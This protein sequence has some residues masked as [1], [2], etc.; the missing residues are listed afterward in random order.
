MTEQAFGP[1]ATL[2]LYAHGPAQ[3]DAVLMGLTESDL[4]LAQTSDAWTIRQIVHHD[5]QMIRQA[6]IAKT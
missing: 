4:N 6:H 5:T 3:L 1:S 2:A